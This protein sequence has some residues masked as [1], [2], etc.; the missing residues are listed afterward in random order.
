MIQEAIQRA[1]RFVE[2]ARQRSRSA[3]RA[4]SKPPVYL[5]NKAEFKF[6]M[7]SGY[8]QDAERR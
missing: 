2:I 6:E 7:T 1:G 5:P 3:H 4:G 8:P